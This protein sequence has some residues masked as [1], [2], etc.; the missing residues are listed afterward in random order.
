LLEQHRLPHARFAT[1]DQRATT[2]LARKLEH[3]LDLRAL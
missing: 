1:D 2:T 3:A